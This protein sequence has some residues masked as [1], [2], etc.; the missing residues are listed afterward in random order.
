M[1]LQEL[2]LSK[3][4]YV[5]R[6]GLS[7]RLVK[8]YLQ[9]KGYE[10]YRSVRI[11]GKEYSL[12]YIMY[13][14]VQRAYDRVESLLRRKLQDKYERF[15]EEITCKGL[16]DFFVYRR[17]PVEE[18]IFVEVKLEHES[19]KP[20][21]SIM[22]KRLEEIGFLCRIIRIKKASYVKVAKAVWDGN[23]WV[24]RVIEKQQKLKKRYPKAFKKGA[25]QVKHGNQN[26]LA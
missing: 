10:V 8:C 15:C 3:F 5:S 22:L 9:K 25:V 26:P 21:Q 2:T 20:C 23:R 11:I 16:P 1:I 19:I 4:P 7:E 17:R 13:D 24:K 6:K 12:R 14:N 18:W